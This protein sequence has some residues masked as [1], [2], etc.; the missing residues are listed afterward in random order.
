MSAG[1]YMDCLS[2]DPEVPFS[3]CGR[4]ALGVRAEEDM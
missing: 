3:A 1:A 4:F 2:S